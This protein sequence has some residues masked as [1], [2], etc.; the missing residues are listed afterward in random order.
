MS[1]TQRVK[2]LKTEIQFLFDSWASNNLTIKTVAAHNL[3]TG[4]LVTL[5]F[6][7]SPQVVSSVSVTTSGSTG[8]IIPYTNEYAL[9]YKGGQVEI[10][11]FLT[12]QTGIVSVFTMPR[13]NTGNP[14]VQSYVTGVNGAS[15]T[16]Q[17]S[18]DGIHWTNIASVTHGTTSGD[19]QYTS[20]TE[21]WVYG[22]I[23]VT[24]IGSATTLTVMVSS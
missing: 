9:P 12:G 7:E 19:T 3:S 13:T 23:N 1:S 14:V 24:S 17:G 20:V 5:K 4:D 10:P 18:L 16:L 2:T 6:D 22:A 15:Y 8:L 21:N 11:Y